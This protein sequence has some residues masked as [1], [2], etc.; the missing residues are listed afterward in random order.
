MFQQIENF[1]D[2]DLCQSFTTYALRE[3]LHNFKPYGKEMPGTHGVY[4]DKFAQA[5]LFN[6]QNRVQ[7]YFKDDIHPSYA[8]YIVYEHGHRL[9]KHVDKN[10]C[11]ITIT[12]HTGHLYGDS[13]KGSTW[14]IFF[15]DTPIPLNV[16]DALM[17]EQKTHK[18]VHWRKPFEGIYQ[19]Q[20]LLHYVSGDKDKI[21]YPVKDLIETA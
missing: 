18:P 7:K 16:G 3:R 19:V 20:L 8:Y 17:Y 12:I 21:P 14:P 5:C 9:T 4:K 15:D 11:E 1:I 10:A 2:D 6:F 13:Y